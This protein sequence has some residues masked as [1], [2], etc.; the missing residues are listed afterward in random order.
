MER[1]FQTKVDIKGTERK[2]K[3]MIEYVSKEDLD[4][5]YDLVNKL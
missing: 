5:L 1:K 4:R 3:I 2:G